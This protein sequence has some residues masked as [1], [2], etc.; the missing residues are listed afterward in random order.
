MVMTQDSPRLARYVFALGV[1][2]HVSHCVF[3]WFHPQ[4]LQDMDQKQHRCYLCSDHH[5]YHS[6]TLWLPC[7]PLYVNL[8]YYWNLAAMSI[9]FFTPYLYS[10]S[11]MAVAS[12][13]MSQSTA[14]SLCSWVHLVKISQLL[15][16]IPTHSAVH[17]QVS[18]F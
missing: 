5:L 7:F 1:F 13:W 11:S 3:S 8:F 10:L 15:W 18:T 16:L 6:S 12:M 2:L 17:C 9:H 4:I 14:W